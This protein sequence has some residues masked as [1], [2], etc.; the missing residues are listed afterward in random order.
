MYGAAYGLIISRADRYSPPIR[1]DTDG[2]KGGCLYRIGILDTA[3]SLAQTDF[4]LNLS[5]YADG[6]A[7]QCGNQGTFD[8]PVSTSNAQISLT[9][10]IVMDMDNRPGGCQM[11]WTVEGRS[12]VLD[13]K[14]IPDG[15]PGQCGNPGIHTASDGNPVRIRLDTD[16]RLGGCRL[17]LRLRAAGT[18]IET[19]SDEGTSNANETQTGH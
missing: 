17:S 5:F 9:H 6:D 18:P 4:K 10:A 3:G 7:G 1:I 11:I 2:R 15:D 12:A 16:D 19:V 13:V 14:F 8:V